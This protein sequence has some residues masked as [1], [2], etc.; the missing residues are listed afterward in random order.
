M[1]FY[2][3]SYIAQSFTQSFPSSLSALFKLELRTEQEKELECLCLRERERE[4]VCV[5]ERERV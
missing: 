1:T 3:V 2:F 5:Y 4:S